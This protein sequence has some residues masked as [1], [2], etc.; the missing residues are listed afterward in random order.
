MQPKVHSSGPLKHTTHYDEAEHLA[1]ALYDQTRGESVR[2]KEAVATVMMGSDR[3]CC[4]GVVPHLGEN[5]MLG[6]HCHELARGPR[7]TAPQA[8]Q[9]DNP[10]AEDSDELDVCRRIVRRVMVGA[11]EDPTRGANAYHTIFENP[12]WARKVNPIASFGKF[13]FYRIPQ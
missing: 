13:L 10:L 7:C 11:L 9:F 4:I 3:P 2:A 12:A 8:P 1:L 6:Q 5:R